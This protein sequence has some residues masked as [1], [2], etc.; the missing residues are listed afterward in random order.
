MRLLIEKSITEKIYTAFFKQALPTDL[1]IALLW[2]IIDILAIFLPVLSDT[3]VR[4][5]L[6]LPG[7]LF[8]PGYCLIAALLPKDSDIDLSERIALSFGLSITVVPLIV[9]G[10]NFTL[11]GDL[12]STYPCIIN[13]IYA[14][15]DLS[16][17][18]Q[19]ISSPV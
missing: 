2:L 14:C 4:L 8:L 9:F 1:L 16:C 11:M 19:E 18:L 12:V 6:I 5:I 10:L 7:I 15:D 17:P 3:P 13:N